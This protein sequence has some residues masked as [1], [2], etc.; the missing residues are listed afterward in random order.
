[1][2]ALLLQTAAFYDL[3]IPLL[4]R[5]NILLK[6]IL[7]SALSKLSA[8]A[9]RNDPRSVIRSLALSVYF[10]SPALGMQK[11]EVLSRATAFLLNVDP[12]YESPKEDPGGIYDHL[13]SNEKRR[14]ERNFKREYGVQPAGGPPGKSLE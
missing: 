7:M 11:Y 4:R 1:M 2:S 9:T 14:M 5:K 6:T 3:G 12:Y 13:G 10:K 8:S